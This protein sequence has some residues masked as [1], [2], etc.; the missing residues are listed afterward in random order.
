MLFKNS[1]YIK[2]NSLKIYMIFSIVLIIIRFTEY[3]CFP[4]SP[5]Y[6]LG[7]YFGEN[8][9]ATPIFYVLIFFIIY[10]VSEYNIFVFA[11]GRSDY[12]DMRHL[13]FLFTFSIINL[14]LYVVIPAL[15]SDPIKIDP[16]HLKKAGPLAMNFIYFIVL[17]SYMYV[18]FLRDL[19]SEFD[20]LNDLNNEL[21]DT[22]KGLVNGEKIYENR[23]RDYQLEID[24]LEMKLKHQLEETKSQLN[25]ILLANGIDHKFP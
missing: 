15:S 25:E 6:L 2:T 19:V 23:F 20:E 11:R 4:S 24:K 18:L 5:V 9:V 12:I 13:I 1:E 14:S 10:L 8:D 3:L 17:A 7:S 22:K 21:K 16:A